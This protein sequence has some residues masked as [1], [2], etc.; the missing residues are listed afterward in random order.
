MGFKIKKYVCECDYCLYPFGPGM[1]VCIRE[2]MVNK[3]H[4]LPLRQCLEK[5]CK[6]YLKNGKPKSNIKEN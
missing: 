6:H 3:D 1:P 4:T 2:R 5:G